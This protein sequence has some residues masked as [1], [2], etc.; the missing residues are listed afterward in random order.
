MATN[1]DLIAHVRSTKEALLDENRADKVAKQHARGKL[2]ARDRIAY[3][4]SEFVEFGGLAGPANNGAAPLVAPADGVV[5]GIGY[6][7]GRPVA[8]A[9]YDFTV[10]GGSN[11]AV[12]MAKLIRCAERS[13]HDGIPFVML[14]DGGGHRMQEA[15]DSRLAGRSGSTS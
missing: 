1:D 2:T 7:D 15:L 3:L 11:G 4:T 14:M 13:L 12:G 9:A 8:L 10:L 5:T 6:V